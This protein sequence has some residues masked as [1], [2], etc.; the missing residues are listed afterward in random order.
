MGSLPFLLAIWLRLFAAFIILLPTFIISD[1]TNTFLPKS[2][3]FYS[4]ILIGALAQ[5]IG[6]AYLWLY[7]SF[8]ISVSVFQIILATLPLFMYAIDVY[9]LKKTKPSFNF[10]LTAI[11]AAVGIALCM[12]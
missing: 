6:A 10:L 8:L 5:T 4:A 2:A 11:V 7:A 1:S 9:F 12:L 3:S